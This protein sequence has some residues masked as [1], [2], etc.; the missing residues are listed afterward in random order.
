MNTPAEQDP[1]LEWNRLNRENAEHGF[2]SAIYLSTCE[3]TAAVDRFSLWLLAGTG[4]SGALLITQIQ[5]VLPHLSS[6]GYKV[7][8]GFLVLSAIFGFIA[9]YKALRCEIQVHSLTRLQAL[10]API[11]EKHGEDED[12][13][14]EFAK[15]REIQLET[16]I[17]IAK[18]LE[19]FSR[20]FPFWVKW[21]IAR[22]VQKAAG[23]RQAGYH[24]AVRAYM[25]Q[26]R[27]TFFQACLFLGFM[28][29]GAWYARA[30]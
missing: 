1:L 27:Y 29:A 20:P 30:I 7:C 19:E 11:F 12:Q 22:Q 9:K 24:V 26:V 15:Q 16:E 14:E 13:I 8:L 17:D 6:T 5:S 4:A 23:D 10:L 21:L 2:V 28:L 3:T 25:S 18:V